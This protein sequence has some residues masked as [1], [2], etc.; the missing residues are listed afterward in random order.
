MNQTNIEKHARRKFSALAIIGVLMVG[1][2]FAV[3]KAQADYGQGAVYQIELVAQGPGGG[4]AWLWIALNG[5][6]TGDYAGS[7]CA[8]G[9]NRGI[10]GEGA[11]R[12]SG[13]IT[14]W[15]TQPCTIDPMARAW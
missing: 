7:D 10:H 1:A 14:N 4:G 2:L 6:G 9:L 5:D 11:A 12:D 13:D 15:Y 3:P 8:G